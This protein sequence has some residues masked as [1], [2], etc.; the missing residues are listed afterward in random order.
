MLWNATRVVGS[1]I[2]AGCLVQPSTTFTAAFTAAGKGDY[3]AY[4][5]AATADE[6]V[7]LSTT[8]LGIRRAGAVL[9]RVG[10]SEVTEATLAAGLMTRELNLLFADAESWQFG[11]ARPSHR[12]AE[13]LVS[14]LGC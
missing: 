14:A 11:V 5:L 4:Y 8:Q 13:G 3:T 9:A 7:V 2:V 12:Q 1:P 10:R 6:L